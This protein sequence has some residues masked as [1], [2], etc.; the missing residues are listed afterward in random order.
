MEKFKEWCKKIKFNEHGMQ[1]ETVIGDDVSVANFIKRLKNYLEFGT[2]TKT[3]IENYAETIAK[4]ATFWYACHAKSFW[5]SV[6]LGINTAKYNIFKDK[7]RLTGKKSIIV[8][9]YPDDSI[10]NIRNKR[11][12]PSR[13]KINDA[14][15]TA[16]DLPDIIGFWP[17]QKKLYENV[18]KPFV[19]FILFSLSDSDLWMTADDEIQGTKRIL[20]VIVNESENMVNAHL[21]HHYKQEK[22]PKEDTEKEIEK[23]NIYK[24]FSDLLK[25]EQNLERM[26]IEYCF[27]AIETTPNKFHV[28]HGGPASIFTIQRFLFDFLEEFLN[29]YHVGGRL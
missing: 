15:I 9:Y 19:E 27:N 26:F 1:V 28:G 7:K 22:N 21:K 4:N 5:D 13:P 2:Y 8:D 10:Y 12:I 17:R 18:N 6:I 14:K 24:D 3:S 29:S 20:S 25:G 16:K 11:D 23:W